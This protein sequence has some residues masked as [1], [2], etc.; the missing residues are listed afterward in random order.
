MQSGSP[1]SGDSLVSR[2]RSSESFKASSNDIFMQ[3]SLRTSPP[4]MSRTVCSFFLLD[5]TD[6]K[7]LEEKHTRNERRFRQL[8]R[9]RAILLQRARDAST[10]KDNFLATLSHELRTPLTSIVGWT[11]L[12]NSETLTPDQVAEGMAA[13]ERNAR[14]QKRLI[15]ELLDLSRMSCGKLNLEF[16]PVNVPALVQQVVDSAKP[17]V[18]EKHQ[19]MRL[20]VSGDIPSIR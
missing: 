18:V 1:Y 17:A 7:T 5:I 8:A 2:Q 10:M 6:R 20:R 19:S 16:S 12:I 14:I 13:I 3:Q 9:E 15:E 4:G 11:A